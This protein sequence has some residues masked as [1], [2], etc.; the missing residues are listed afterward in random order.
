MRFCVISAAKALF[1]SFQSGMNVALENPML[2]FSMK[3]S[4]G[5]PSE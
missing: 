3:R 4:N 1:Q 2:R 5:K